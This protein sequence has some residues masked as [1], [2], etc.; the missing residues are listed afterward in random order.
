MIN[1]IIH[2]QF[3]PI[4]IFS[5]T[6]LG[7]GIAAL[8]SDTEAELILNTMLGIGNLFVLGYFTLFQE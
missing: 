5:L 3:T 8:L 6:T 7:F 2:S 4:I 1:K